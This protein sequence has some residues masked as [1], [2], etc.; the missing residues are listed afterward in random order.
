M[1]DEGRRWL[2]RGLYYWKGAGEDCTWS[3]C[4]LSRSCCMSSTLLESSSTARPIVSRA[5][6]SGDTGLTFS[7]C[8][9]SIISV[10]TSPIYKT[11]YIF[12][13]SHFWRSWINLTIHCLWLI[14][15]GKHRR[16][17][18]SILKLACLLWLLLT[19]LEVEVLLNYSQ[20]NVVF[21]AHAW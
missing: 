17:D 3:W 11:P 2:S 6:W 4:A 18:I 7:R 1:M 20:C 12:Y 14:V 8:S 19:Y 16:C 5:S 21:G 9:S 15:L 10:H 13:A